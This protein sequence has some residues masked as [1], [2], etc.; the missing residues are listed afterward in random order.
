[1]PVLPKPRHEAFAQARAQGKTQEQAYVEAGYSP[2][3]GNACRLTGNDR[4]KA[5]V[6]ELQELAVNRVIV[7]KEWVMAQLVDNAISYKDTNPAVANRAL[8]LLGKELGMFVERT[9][10]ENRTV[11]Y[12]EEPTTLDEWLAEHGGQA[13]K[14]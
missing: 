1:M 8:E 7:D 12:S 5:R 11:I 13:V 6:Q 9:A 10:N 14:H 4:I 3:D 2:D